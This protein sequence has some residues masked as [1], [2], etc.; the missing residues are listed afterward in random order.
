MFFSKGDE[1]GGEYIG[2]GQLATEGQELGTDQPTEEDHHPGTAEGCLSCQEDLVWT[3]FT[4][5]QGEDTNQS[6]KVAGIQATC[7]R[8]SGGAFGLAFADEASDW[9]TDD[10]AEGC[11]MHIDPEECDPEE[12]VLE[13]A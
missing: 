6:E 4:D 9:A 11:V 12:F 10:V 5:G 7:G 2:E 1:E 8:Q 3:W 13:E